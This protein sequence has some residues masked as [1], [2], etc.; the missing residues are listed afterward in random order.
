[1]ALIQVQ[2]IL[3]LGL[4]QTYQSRRGRVPRRKSRSLTFLE[5]Q[6]SEE[7]LAITSHPR[8]QDMTPVP[9]SWGQG[10]G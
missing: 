2:H 1:M 5:V 3:Y 4:A 6:E 8:T 9:P 10:M 7:E